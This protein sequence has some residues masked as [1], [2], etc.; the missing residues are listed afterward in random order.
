M[1]EYIDVVL[2]YD[3]VPDGTTITIPIITEQYYIFWENSNEQAYPNIN[4]H[5]YTTGGQ[6]IINIRIMFTD[7][8]LLYKNH[9]GIDKT[10]L[11]SCKLQFTSRD[12]PAITAINFSGCSGL[13]ELYNYRSNLFI[14]DYSSDG[15]DVS[16]MFE[17]CTS[18]SPSFNEELKDWDTYNFT[19]MSFM[20]KGCSAFTEKFY[21]LINENFYKDLTFESMFEGSSVKEVTIKLLN[22]TDNYTFNTTNMFKNCKN[23]TNF[24]TINFSISSDSIIDNMFDGAT[25]C[26]ID[27]NKYIYGL[28]EPGKRTLTTLV[29]ND[30]RQWTSPTDEYELYKSDASGNKTQLV[31]QSAVSR[32]SFNTFNF[33][34]KNDILSSS[35]RYVALVNKT[36]PTSV[37]NS[38]ILIPEAVVGS[39]SSMQ[40]MDIVLVYDNV[41]DGT[42]ITIPIIN[43]L[44]YIYWENSEQYNS[45]NTHTY[46]TGGKIIIGIVCID[47]Y[48]SLLYKN[49][50]GIDKTYLTSCTMQFSPIDGLNIKAINFSGCSRL[51]NFNGYTT[52]N[53]FIHDYSSDGIDV[54]YMFEDCTSLSPNVTKYFKNWDTYNFTNMSF[55]FKGCT[56]FTENFNILINENF[57]KELTFESMFEG[58]SVKEVTMEIINSTENYTF[59]TTNMFKNCKNLTN[60]ST[61]DFSISGDSII[62]NM[63]E[64]AINCN[65]DLYKCLFTT[66]SLM[67][68]YRLLPNNIVLYDYKQWTSA[69]D[70]YE[71]YKSDKNDYDM[72]VGE[73]ISISAVLKQPDGAF[74]FQINKVTLKPSDNWVVMVNKTNPKS[75]YSTVRIPNLVVFND[76]DIFLVYDNVPDGTTITIP[77]I[78]EQYFIY[79]ENSANEKTTPNINTH[80]YTTGGKII[81]GIRIIYT[82]FSLL[83][84]NHSGIDKTYL[85]SCTLQFTT[86]DP[87]R[88]EAINFS[89]CSSLI[90]IYN[91]KSNLFIHDYSSDGIDVSYMFE[92]CT[93]LNPSFIKDVSIWDTYNFNNMSF[94]FKGC[95]TFT[96]NFNILINENFYKELTFESMFEGSGVKEVTMEII[97]STENYTFNTTNMF[98]NC[99]NLTN[100]NIIDF[101]ISS[102]SIIANMFEGATQ[103]NIDMNKIVNA[104]TVE[105]RLDGSIKVID[106]HNWASTSDAYA[107]FTSNGEQVSALAT[108]DL[109]NNSDKRTF[110]FNPISEIPNEIVVM[111]NM[112]NILSVYHG[113]INASY[114][115]S[116]Y[117]G[118][119]TTS[120]DTSNKNFDIINLS[121]P[122]FNGGFYF[123]RFKST[124]NNLSVGKF[125]GIGTLSLQTIGK[126]P[127]GNFTIQLIR[128]G[129]QR[130]LSDQVIVG[131]FNIDIIESMICFKEGTKIL[132]STGYVPIERLQQGQLVKT[133]NNN[134][135]PIVLIGK[136]LIYHP[137]KSERIPDQ[138]YKY[139]RNT[140]PGLVDDLVLT[141]KHS[142]L[143]NQLNE[144]EKQKTIELLGNDLVTDNK[145]KLPSCIDNR[146]SVYEKQ[147][148]HTIYHLALKN[149]NPHG[150]YGIFANGL[151][152]ETCSIYIMQ[153]HSNMKIFTNKLPLLINV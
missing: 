18:L 120:I 78:N 107:L 29:L 138:L 73:K 67:D 68:S 63:F 144:Y 26:N 149:T 100:F 118:L 148:K 122:V 81:I 66:P 77:I 40:S 105:R 17:D 1:T 69:N 116:L 146:A 41:P 92:D 121:C 125:S 11:T 110:I 80:T 56:T 83:Y 42:T 37:Y 128:V 36:H 13:T 117:N 134:Y 4:T 30:N 25:Q 113:N 90:G 98:K 126:L 135:L 16:Y 137:A 21:I 106:T 2:V 44:Y 87:P 151:L 24:S 153:F 22:F 38:S 19:N 99:K 55:M 12:S 129:T 60:F 130:S 72:F 88:I 147:G 114:S 46:T 14:H 91:D 64:G 5:T 95:T 93:S 53:L 54:S 86:H 10:Y 150:K 71:L 102:D 45:T 109:T 141:G 35:D 139:S 96:E 143:V 3:N 65:V 39:S 58:S 112:T 104:V 57:Y 82:D 23:L 32:N 115:G 61:I 101:S 84:K 119:T 76:V 132:T 59:N 34:I 27:I 52:T 94:M 43:D 75:V 123:A 70:E 6:K 103:C 33:N 136:K 62:A 97:N 15:I 51:T 50:S 131:E 20:F 145:Y 133:L 31:S 85:T 79:W 111:K 142:I 108:A 140:F 47:I 74:Y 127:A 9:S 152:V 7:F 124:T 49:H 89:G 48:I 28:I 8:S